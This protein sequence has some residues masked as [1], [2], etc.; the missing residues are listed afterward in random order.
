MKSKIA[1]ILIL[2]LFA[3]SAVGIGCV[4]QVEGADVIKLKY[5]AYWPLSCPNGLVT[6][7]WMKEIEQRTGGSIKWKAYWAQSLVKAAEGLK[8]LSAGISDANIVSVGYSHSDL[9]LS[10]AFELPFIIPSS[11]IWVKMKVVEELYDTY[12]PFRDEW[13]KYGVK[14][15]GLNPVPSGL[16][17]TRKKQIKTLEDLKGIKLRSYGYIGKTLNRLGAVSVSMPAPEMYTAVQRGTVDGAHFP[18]ASIESFKMH[19]VTDY[20][21]LNTGLEIYAC[22]IDVMNLKTWEELPS[23]IKKIIDQVNAE[24]AESAARI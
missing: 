12:A 8:A 3:V 14:F 6:D 24:W 5:A 16:L 2:A 23:S 13:T 9:P 20:I 19:E 4:G 17:I 7:W 10:T 22:L 18:L 15:I 21:T 11:S 1:H